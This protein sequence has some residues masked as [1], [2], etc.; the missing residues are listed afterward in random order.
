M[1]FLFS[2][3]PATFWVTISY[4]ILYSS[5]KTDGAIRKFGQILAVWILIVA[6]FFPLCGAYVSISGKC[7]INKII[8]KVETRFAN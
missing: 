1:C 7:P 8:Q 6:I 2:L 5:S 3:I 4:F